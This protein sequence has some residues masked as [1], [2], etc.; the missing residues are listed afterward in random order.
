MDRR[1]IH[2][3]LVEDDQG[4]TKL[5]RRAFDRASSDTQFNLTAASS[6]EKARDCLT[7]FLPDMVIADWILPDGQGV[8]LLLIGDEPYKTRPFPVVIMTS[9]GDEHMAVEAIKAGALDYVVKSTD[10]LA[11][12]PHVVERALR[13]WGYI[14]D[15]RRAEEETKHL[16]NYLKNIVD[17]M[18]SILVG[19]DLE[20]RVTQ[21][22]WE[23]EKATGVTA[24][25]AQ[26]RALS[27]VF[28]QLT[29]EM[30]KVR[31]TIRDRLPQKNE[32]VVR[33]NNG[34]KYYSDVTIYPLVVNGVEGAVI[35]VD[36]VTERVRIEEMMLR[37][38]KMAS[39][40]GL[41]A[42]VAHEINNPLGAMMQSAQILQMNFDTKLPRTRE[43]LQKCGVDPDGLDR[44]LQER[45]L[46]E[47]LNGI[48]TVGERAAKI[49]SDLLSFSHKSSS[50]T[51]PHDLNTLVRQTL[52]L[53]ATDYDLKKKYDFRDMEIIW[54][55]APNLPHVTCDGQQIQQ[56]V[57]NLV[58]NVAQAIAE[59]KEK[60]GQLTLRTSWREN[61]ARLEVE[62][63][64]PGIPEDRR[65]R[66]FEPF[67][68]TKEVGEGTGLGLWL[69]WSIVVERH[70]GRIW[71]EA[72]VEGGSRFVIELP[73]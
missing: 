42:G 40:G 52:D 36:D 64:G 4:H 65:T 7:E 33:E 16:R 27:D 1:T 29:D 6:L 53:A 71:A 38:A 43:R 73:L 60:K 39:I 45:K 20:G 41:A 19:V 34:E 56:A 51:K 3:L 10:T 54:N 68:T 69:C 63:N 11:D 59:K 35:R 24:I 17:S 22:N 44:Y 37:S 49:V 67:F 2:I 70:Q 32:K 18:P 72:T 21:W 12:M 15:R 26:G 48:R 14:T 30:E 13:E 9:H 61:W 5:I 62:D 55:L 25:E 66:L 28:P 58:R 8:E 50:E 23:A 46:N 47:Y 31:Q 57:L